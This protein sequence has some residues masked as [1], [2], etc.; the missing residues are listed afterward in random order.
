[1]PLEDFHEHFK[2]RFAHHLGDTVI[3]ALSG[4][5]DSVALLHLLRDHRLGLVLE[6]A[7]VHHAT[8]G[9]EADRDAAFC[10][11]L[12][13]RL[14]LPFHLLRITPEQN[15]PDG[16]E[17]SWRRLRYG[18]L[19]DLANRRSAGALATAHHRDDISEGVLVQLLRGAGPRALAGI[20][21]E[22]DRGIIRPLL[23]WRRKDIVLW[24]HRHGIGWCEDSSNQD[25]THLRNRV[26]HMILPDLR[27]ASP[28]IDEH[29]VHLATAIAED[30]DFFSDHLMQRTTWIDPS[31]PD[32][33]V[34]CDELI[35]MPRSL[36]SRWLHAQAARAGIGQVT[37][38]QIEL[39]QR[40]IETSRPRSVSLAGRWRIRRARSRLWL[41][42]PSDPAGY[43]QILGT[44][45]EVALTIPGWR[46]RLTLNGSP[47]DRA[48][49]HSTV[50]STARLCLRTP[51]PE[52]TVV[53][54]GC[55]MNVSRLIAKR[56]PRHL[57]AAWPVLCEN[58]RITWIPGVWQGPESGDLLLEVFTHG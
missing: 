17:A 52:D 11:C 10:E 27:V 48:R 30:E 31:C 43:E 33:G 15:P 18:T 36:R 55:E 28:R 21:E 49:W 5:P 12:S 8:R 39:F 16:R 47:S 22:T 25:I 23:P 2:R 42:P 4:G 44:D 13:D 24:L 26:R 56:A 58:A 35:S 41:E 20:H 50:P 3:V 46:V 38:R 57:R 1:M 45:G 37:R 32:G 34:A 14:G 53:I 51:T 7:H 6:A 9:I 54:D 29:L 19:L 40:L